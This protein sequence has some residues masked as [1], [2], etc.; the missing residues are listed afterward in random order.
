MSR[1]LLAWELGANYGHL[2]QLA[3]VG[4]ALRAHGHELL[5]A[6]RDLSGAAEMLAPQGFHFTQAP[7]FHRRQR[8]PAPPASHAEML[9]LSGYSDEA[10][11]RGLAGGWMGLLRIHRPDAIVADH[12]PGAILA[13]R[14]AAVP[15]VMIGTGFEIPPLESPLPSIRPW[16]RISEERL[17][18]SE[19]SLLRL[20]NRI[21]RSL[22]GRELDILADWF[23]AEARLHTTFPELDP[24]GPRRG[25]SYPGPIYEYA[26]GDPL[27]WPQCDL[28]RVFA[29]LRGDVPGA[30]NILKALSTAAAATV[31]VVPGVRPAAVE[32]LA[33]ETLRIVSRP[34]P[35]KSALQEAALVLTYGGHGLVCAALTAGVPLLL[36]PHT[37]EQYLHARRVVAN[38]AGAL[39][40]GDRG[41]ETVSARL[42]QVLGDDRLQSGA[43][44]FAA[45][46]AGCGPAG[47]AARVARITGA[48][49]PGRRHP[50]PAR[51]VIP[52]GG[53]AR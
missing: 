32:G 37:V 45:G 8:A 2:R 17:R 11:A 46:H 33:S 36:A 47:A 52:Q 24:F 9:A 49:A 53:A 35:L 43:R 26:S 6:V 16:E 34:V 44:Q 13:G 31:C 22:G 7:V 29:Y 41:V 25:E 21:L 23:R 20:V 18:R 50:T 5:F 38:G 28:P 14:I 48:L 40:E 51:A 10:T 15:V 27:G 3:A 42:A 19:R 1:I 4:Q 12:A 39:I 30:K